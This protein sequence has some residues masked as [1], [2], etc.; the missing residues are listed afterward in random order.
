[1]EQAIL[2]IGLFSLVVFLVGSWKRGRRR[3]RDS[4]TRMQRDMQS[5]H[6]DLHKAPGRNR[7]AR[8]R[9]PGQGWR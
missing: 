9:G 7:S 8:Y 2:F 4:T 1:M 3:Q 5:F 6:E